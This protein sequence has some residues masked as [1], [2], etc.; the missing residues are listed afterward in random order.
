MSSNDRGVTLWEMF[1]SWLQR[2][3]N[4][5]T[6]SMPIKMPAQ[7]L[8]PLRWQLGAPVLFGGAQGDEFIGARTRLQAIRHVERIS[9]GQHFDFVDYVLEVIGSMN[10]QSIVRV[11]AMQNQ[12][13]EWNTALLRLHDAFDYD[14]QFLEV[15]NDPSGEFQIDDDPSGTPVKFCRLTE[16]DPW[17]VGVYLQRDMDGDQQPDDAT[18]PFHQERYW[19]YNRT[20]E[21]SEE[22]LLFVEMEL[23]NGRFELWRGKQ[24]RV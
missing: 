7:P 14:A 1:V 10:N 8:N 2:Q 21:Q 17:E 4:G 9:E 22:E 20:T 5:I 15:V 24:V 6:A 19:D 3:S 11:R 16:G 23:G 13:G 18:P 12:Q